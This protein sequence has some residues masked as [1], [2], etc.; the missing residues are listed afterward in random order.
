MTKQNIRVPELAPR[1][2]AI[3][4]FKDW[5]QTWERWVQSTELATLFGQASGGL[6]LNQYR[7]ILDQI[8]KKDTILYVRMLYYAQMECDECCDLDNFM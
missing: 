2:L 1:L 8:S 3:L 4:E 5:I 6:Y 7:I